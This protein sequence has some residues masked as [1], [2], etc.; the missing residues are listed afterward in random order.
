MGVS[1]FLYSLEL[2]VGPTVYVLC[3]K[4]AKMYYIG[5]GGMGV[6]SYPEYL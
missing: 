6:L 5:G 4:Y 3:T 1:Q 2:H